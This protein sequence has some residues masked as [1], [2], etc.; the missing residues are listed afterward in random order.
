MRFRKFLEDQVGGVLEDQVGGGG[1]RPEDT[2]P[3]G[4]GRQQEMPGVQ[5]S[6]GEED[7]QGEV[8]DRS[9]QDDFVTITIQDGNGNEVN[10]KMS[11]R[12]W[13]KKGAPQIGARVHA[14]WAKDGGLQD[15]KVYHDAPTKPEADPTIFQQSPQSGSGIPSTGLSFG[16]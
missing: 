13:K 12:F 1:T 11:Y 5:M 8:I 16:P 6:L 4:S 14:V 15:L 9:I 3:T 2:R 10:L 7:I